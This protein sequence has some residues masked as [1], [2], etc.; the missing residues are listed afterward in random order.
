MNIE[1]DGPVGQ[2]GKDNRESPAA[3]DPEPE[4]EPPYDVSTELGAEIQRIRQAFANPK[5]PKE[6]KGL[7]RPKEPRKPAYIGVEW[8]KKNKDLDFLY[9]KGHILVRDAYIA[10][11]RG[12]LGGGA[13]VDGL[14]DGVSLYSI[15][16]A[17]NTSG[18]IHA[19]N[20]IDE[21][22]GVGV[23]APNYVLWA[24]AAA[25]PD[26][27][28]LCPATDPEPVSAGSGPNP[29]E[30][31]GRDGSGVR[32]HVPD[33]G[34]LDDASTHPWLI[35]VT[36]DPDPQLGPAGT[37]PRIEPY[38]GHGTFIAGVARC[39]APLSDVHVA[40]LLKFAGT[41][42][43]SEIVKHL[44]RELDQ[45]PDIISLSA[46][47][48][49]W[50]NHP[51]L[52]MQALWRRYRHYK[53]L[54]LVAAA[55]NNGNRRPFWPAAFPQVV[56]VGAL[57]SNWRSRASFSDYGGWVDVYAPGENLVNAFAT[58]NYETCWSPNF[59]ANAQ[60][61]EFNGMARWSGT[62]FSTPLVAGLIAA[63]MSRTGENSRQAADTLLAQARAQ[64]LP[65]VGPVLYPC[66]SGPD[67]HCRTEERCDRCHHCHERR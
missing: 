35:G 7:K 4:K 1:H 38:C 21:A 53:G 33:T 28:H 39:M 36:G 25:S 46:G 10:R 34:L 66:D 3:Q 14:I 49:T 48:T 58:G 65:G 37:E 15:A 8:R 29:G 2:E 17:K 24:T 44:D 19:L 42:L 23:A 11:V 20:L 31:P 41:E 61:R 43:E 54:L 67:C 26:I 59:G 52:A 16:K 12:V 27:G 63:R 9:Q 62:S 18:A 57:S 64:A 60:T 50:R 40:S 51:P 47:T 45:H 22:L 32:I 13:V 56:S 30:C 5:E 55:S 6:Q